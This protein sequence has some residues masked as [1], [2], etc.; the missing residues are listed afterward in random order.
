MEK[1][2]D[3]AEFI[4]KILTGERD[5][6]RVIIKEKCLMNMFIDYDNMIDYLK[7]QDQEG[8]LEKNPI[9]LNGAELIGIKAKRLYFPYI[10]AECIDLEH[11]ILPEANFYNANFTR[12]LLTEAYLVKANLR[13]AKLVGASLEYT[14][15]EKSE[16]EEIDLKGAKIDGANFGKAK[17]G[18]KYFWFELRKS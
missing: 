14:D 12:A 10:Q 2:I 7:K 11:A 16:L 13:K 5:F 8:K 4:K 6:S 17:F 9:I 3:G 1:R 18:R 15:F